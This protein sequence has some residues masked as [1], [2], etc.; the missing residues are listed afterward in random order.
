M[1][2]MTCN[3]GNKA[4]SLLLDLF[5]TYLQ[6][7][8]CTSQAARDEFHK[9][10]GMPWPTYSETRWFSKYDVLEK[11]SKLFPDLLAVMVEII[12]KKLSPKNLKKLLDMLMDPI[13]S[14][15]LQIHLCAYVEALFPLRNLC[16]W[17]ES[18]ATDLPFKVA[19]R[20]EKFEALFPQGRMMELPGTRALIMR[21]SKK[22]NL[23][24]FS[25]TNISIRQSNGLSSRSVTVAEDSRK[26]TLALPCLQ[27]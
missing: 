8:F 13:L 26:T 1:S 20:I 11:L 17:L 12:K 3:G 25:S 14:W 19:E 7:V 4:S 2:H 9:V 5:W 21:V 24:R 10:T 15:R 18:D 22:I 16:Y 23:L 27:L 6:K